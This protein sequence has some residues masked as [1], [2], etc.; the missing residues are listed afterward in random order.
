MSLEN[1]R[2]SYVDL[3]VI[4]AE[5]QAQKQILRDASKSSTKGAASSSSGKPIKTQTSFRV[6]ND[7]GGAEN[8]KNETAQSPLH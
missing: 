2:D 8:Y 3:L 4:K 7:V 5:Q 1:A 6:K